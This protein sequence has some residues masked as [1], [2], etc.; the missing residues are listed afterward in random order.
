VSDVNSP[1]IPWDFDGPKA[2][3]TCEQIAQEPFVKLG[4]VNGESKILEDD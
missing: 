1:R 2:F 4:E 3:Q